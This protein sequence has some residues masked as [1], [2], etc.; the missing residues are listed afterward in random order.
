MGVPVRVADMTWDQSGSFLLLA[1]CCG[2]FGNV[3]G[4]AVL[5]FSGSTLTETV[6]PT[7]VDV[8]Y[9]Q[10]V[11]SFVY[12]MQGCSTISCQGPTGITG[13]NFQNGQLVT[14]P[15]SPY[16]YGHDSYMVIY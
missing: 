7:G 14:L 9:I 11:G 16:P 3:G 8:F 15:G 2:Q 5:S 13:F 4:A 6:Y 1:T 12:T 10:M